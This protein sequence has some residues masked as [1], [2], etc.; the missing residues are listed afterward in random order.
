MKV[1]KRVDLRSPH[2]KKK[3]CQVTDVSYTYCGDHF[4]KNTNMDH[5]VVHL[6][7]MARY[8]SI[9]FQRKGKKDLTQGFL[10]MFKTKMKS[11]VQLY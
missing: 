4:A 9:I 8:M 7:L 11:S 2:H 10:K 5:Y 6:K 3:N 1:A